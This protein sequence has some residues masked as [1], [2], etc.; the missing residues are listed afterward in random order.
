[1][2]EKV[3][4]AEGYNVQFAK[5]D[6]Y[7]VKHPKLIVVWICPKG[8]VQEDVRTEQVWSTGKR[9]LGRRAK[10]CS[11]PRGTETLC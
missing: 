3:K 2:Q 7:I 11:V 4:C 8:H 5:R 6:G 10:T 1:M 9:S